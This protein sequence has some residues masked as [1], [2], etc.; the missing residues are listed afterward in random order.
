MIIA[1][2]ITKVIIQAI[3]KVT[4]MATVI[5]MVTKGTIA[6]QMV[7]VE[8]IMMELRLDNVI[9]VTEQAILR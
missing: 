4:T 8:P 6:I 5:I 9:S 7:I 2:T 3:I 1:R